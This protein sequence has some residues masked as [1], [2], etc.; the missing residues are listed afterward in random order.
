MN[1]REVYDAHFRF[2]W[3]TLRRLGVRDEDCGDAAQEVFLVVHRKLSEFEGKSKITTWL[4]TICMRV[5]RDRRRLAHVRYE[6]ISASPL[7]DHADPMSDVTVRLAE[8]EGAELLERA[9]DALTLEQRAVFTL[10]ELEE[11]TRQQIAELLDLPE[12]TVSSRLR[13]SRE[14]FRDRLAQLRAAQE[15]ADRRA[16]AHG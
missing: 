12:G 11:L 10:F 5:A 8:R 13:T 4:Y 1:F 2:V 6:T 14:I 3:R 9:L 7:E 15:K 16:G